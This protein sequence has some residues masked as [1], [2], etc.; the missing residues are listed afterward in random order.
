MGDARILIVDDDMDIRATLADLLQDEG[1]T[2]SAVANGREALAYL[3]EHL[4]TSVVLLDLMMPVMDGF[5]FR[6]EQ[7][8]DPQLASIPIVAMT[9]GW[10]I[11]PGTIDVQ[12]IVPKPLNLP[13][14]LEAIR[15]AEEN[16][17]T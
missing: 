12:E 7:K 9:A 5:Q 17:S 13:S 4:F 1:Y 15:R 11:E 10:P 2:V 14:L 6:A 3:R 16:A 8:N